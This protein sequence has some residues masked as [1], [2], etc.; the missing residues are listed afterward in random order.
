MHLLHKNVPFKWEEKCEA[1]FN[2]IKYYLMNPLVLVLP[3]LGEP[4]ILYISAIEVS[5]GALLAQEDS[6]GKESAI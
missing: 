2:Q 5:L 4:L 6:T 1:A 3:T